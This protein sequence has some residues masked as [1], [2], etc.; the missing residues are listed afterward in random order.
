[1]R[2]KTASSD[3]TKLKALVN[4][5]KAKLTS[6]NT[7]VHFIGVCW[8]IAFSSMQAARSCCSFWYV[9]S[10]APLSQI[11][12]ARLLKPISDA[13]MCRW[14][15]QCNPLIEKKLVTALASLLRSEPEPV[16]LRLLAQTTLEIFTSTIDD[17]EPLLAIADVNAVPEEFIDDYQ[18]ESL[19]IGRTYAVLSVA[20]KN[21]IV[22]KMKHQS[23][24]CRV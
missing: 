22:E 2:L 9:F 18:W 17:R 5:F 14:L 20:P 11:T 15:T 16:E 12:P 6:A 23:V 7:Q 3:D 19:Q 24:F 1:M 13:N 21:F 10:Y 4:T 8:D